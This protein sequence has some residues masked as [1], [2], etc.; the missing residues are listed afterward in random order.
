MLNFRLG[1]EPFENG[2]SRLG[3][4]ETMVEV[5]ADA[6]REAGDF[7]SAFHGDMVSVGIAVE[8]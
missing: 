1:V 5:V 7:A 3:G 2:L 4:V 8:S 6:A